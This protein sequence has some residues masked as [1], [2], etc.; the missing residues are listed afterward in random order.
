[1]MRRACQP[2]QASGATWCNHD[3]P[4]GPQRAADVTPW[5]LW[6][7]ATVN[8]LDDLEGPPMCEPKTT[9]GLV[10]IGLR[11]RFARKPEPQPCHCHQ[12]AALSMGDRFDKATGTAGKVLAGIGVTILLAAMDLIIHII[13]IAVGATAIL[14]LTG[15]VIYLW[16]KQHQVRHPA[17]LA[18][19]ERVAQIVHARQQVVTTA[20]IAAIGA[21]EPVPV[22][23]RR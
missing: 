22:R 13:V 14:A 23:A 4:H 12:P 16:R 7:F 1:M 11:A 19:P 17:A 10:P 20:A 6:P 21:P 2:C 15:L 5:W 18:A 9:S 3:G 8:R